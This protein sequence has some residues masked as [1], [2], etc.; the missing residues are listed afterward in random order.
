[1]QQAHY[2]DEFV[3]GSG[4]D[5]YTV[6]VDSYVDDEDDGV[7]A[8]HGGGGGGGGGG[9]KKKKKKKK[10]GCRTDADWKS[11]VEHADFDT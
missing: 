7:E 6:S 9:G 4:D 10:R 3:F 8:E 11:Y 5:E 2:V 1:M